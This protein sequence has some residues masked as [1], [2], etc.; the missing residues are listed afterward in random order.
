MVLGQRKF[1]LNRFS[2]RQVIHS[3]QQVA[4]LPRAVLQLLFLVVG[5]LL[6]VARPGFCSFSDLINQINRRRSQNA[7][8]VLQVLGIEEG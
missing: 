8:L 6:Q 1:L 2:V 5:Q 3:L 4:E 7:W